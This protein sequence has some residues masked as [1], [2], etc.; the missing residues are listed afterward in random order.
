MDWTTFRI[1]YVFAPV[2]NV[3]H[4]WRRRN[5]SDTVIKV[6]NLIVDLSGKIG[7]HSARLQ[8]LKMCLSSHVAPPFL[9]TKIV[10]AGLCVSSRSISLFLEQEIIDAETSLIVWKQSR[11]RY[12]CHMVDTLT[13][14]DIV[15]LYKYAWHI[16]RQQFNSRS[17]HYSS[18]LAWLQG[19]LV[20]SGGGIVNSVINFSNHTLSVDEINAVQF[21]PGD[22]VKV[23]SSDSEIFTDMELLVN[24]LNNYTPLSDMHKKECVKTVGQVGFSICRAIK[25]LDKTS[26]FKEQTVRNLRAKG[27]DI[28]KP[29]KGNAT[30]ICPHDMYIE[31]MNLILSDP[32]KFEFVGN[33]VDFNDTKNRQRISDSLQ[34]C[35]D[36][37]QFPSHIIQRIL[38]KAGIIPRLYGLPK[39]HKEGTPFRPVLSMINSHYHGLAK[40]LLEKVL[41]PVI[42]Q[43]S[44]HTVKDTFDFVAKLQEIGPVSR[45]RC[46]TFD[47]QSLFTNVPVREVIDII[48]ECLYTSG[49]SP[50]VDMIPLSRENLKILLEL[51][52]LDVEFSFDGKLWR[53]VDGMAMGSPLGPAFANIFVG[54]H[55]KKLL[56]QNCPIMYSRYVD[57]IFVVC[58][59]SAEMEELTASLGGMH[60][61]LVFTRDT[62][63]HFLDVQIMYEETAVSTTV[64]RKPSFTGLYLQYNAFCPARYKVNLVKTLCYRARRIC[65]PHLLS[66]ELRVIRDILCRNGFPDWF[67]TKHMYVHTDD[68]TDGENENEATHDDNKRV[69]CRVP[70]T[71][72]SIIPLTSK[73]K[74][75]VSRAYAG[76]T[77][78]VVYKT[79]RL[80]T[81]APKDIIPPTQKSNVVYEFKCP[82]GARYV[83]RT[84]RPLAVRVKEHL[85]KW[86][87]SSGSRSRSTLPPTSSVT[88]HLMNCPHRT[89]IDTNWFRILQQCDSFLSL[90]VA[91]AVAIKLSSPILCKDKEFVFITTV[92]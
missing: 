56:S 44:T 19:R 88:K 37:G 15:M 40:Y 58:E 38:P 2:R 13:N 78:T 31:K 7:Y 75:A 20:K 5:Y 89:H 1:L 47:V 24:Q 61:S 71:G 86:L 73:I 63:D 33:N 34:Q 50:K 48:L 74:R 35:A 85:P 91:E 46:Q 83:G 59:S 17:I 3:F 51:C 10:K 92:I 62:P 21:G 76:L 23:K 80:S 52:S 79:R 25:G 4:W 82:C 14:L 22:Y 27:L 90:R 55:E 30:V 72:S 57:D 68:N 32:L 39:T 65:S 81:N 6:L 53:Q 36:Q 42:E 45:D 11:H 28:F 66:S 9:R 64:Y 29:D 12:L 87:Y 26:H 8:Y 16:Y 18:T 77:T 69:I 54:F 41:P 70:Y 67:I 60:A 43:F 84:Q 49:N